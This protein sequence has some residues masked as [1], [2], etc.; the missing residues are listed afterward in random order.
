MSYDTSLADSS[1][2]REEEADSRPDADLQVIFSF[3]APIGKPAGKALWEGRKAAR[4]TH[5][6]IDHCSAVAAAGDVS[7][8]MPRY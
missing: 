3:E 8:A 1:V 4:L 7:L 6:C 5:G 2:L